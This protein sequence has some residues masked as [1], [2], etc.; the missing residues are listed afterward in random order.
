MDT[1][2][3]AAADELP[4]YYAC[5]LRLWRDHPGAMWR[6]TLVEPVSG[7]RYNFASLAELILFV[8]RR[9]GTTLGALSRESGDRGPQEA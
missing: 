2:N 3:R 7:A 8:E 9:T 4:D 6:A 5:L 1:D